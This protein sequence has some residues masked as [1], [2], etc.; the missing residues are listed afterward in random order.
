[1]TL[2]WEQTSPHSYIATWGDGDWFMVFEDTWDNLGTWIALMCLH[3]GCESITLGDEP[4]VVDGVTFEEAKQACQ[5]LIDNPKDALT[6]L[7]AVR[8]GPLQSASE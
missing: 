5:N 2:N 8:L 3:F 1:M 7:L 4:I 6:K